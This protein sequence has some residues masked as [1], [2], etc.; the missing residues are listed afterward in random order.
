MFEAA[1][2]VEYRPLLETGAASKR[3]WCVVASYGH[4]WRFSTEAAATS[5]AARFA[6]QRAKARERAIEAEWRGSQCLGDANEAAERGDKAKAAALYDKAQYWLDRYNRLV[7][8][9]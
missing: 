9:S 4:V 2:T 1:Y 5:R 6:T 7:G 3:P 8:N